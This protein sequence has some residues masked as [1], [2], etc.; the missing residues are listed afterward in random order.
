MD[1]HFKKTG[2]GAPLILLHGLLGSLDN[3]AAFAEVAAA[4]FTVYSVDQRNHGLS[5]HAEEMNYESM[6]DDLA[7]FADSHALAQ[8]FVLGHSMGGKTAMQFALSFPARVAKLVVV[9]IAPRAYSPRHTE[10]FE[11]LLALDLNFIRS[12]TEAENELAKKIPNPI[13][14]RF[15]L[16]NLAGSEAGGLRWKSNVPGI[17]KNYPQLYDAIPGGP[18]FANPALFVAGGKSHHLLESDLPQIREIFPLAEFQ[19]LPNASH[20]VHADA[21]AEFAKIVLE[22]LR[23]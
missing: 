6:A 8:T 13:V 15:L 5:P 3:L 9:D 20:W 18:S 21:P 16:K 17:S 7:R 22:F 19:T 1:L 14:R 23:R 12:R 2:H 11:A 4:H 10:I